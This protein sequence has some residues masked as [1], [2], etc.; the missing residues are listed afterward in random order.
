MIPDNTVRIAV[1]QGIKT[2]RTIRA[3]SSLRKTSQFAYTPEE[4][5]AVLDQQRVKRANADMAAYAIRKR[6]SE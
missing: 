5:A 1:R 2:S 6:S 3:A 4:M